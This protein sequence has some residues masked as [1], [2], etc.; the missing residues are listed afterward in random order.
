MTMKKTEHI[1]IDNEHAATTLKMEDEFG[2][3]S[4]VHLTYEEPPAKEST[5]STNGIV[6]AAANNDITSTNEKNA[7]TNEIIASTNE[8]IASAN[9]ITTL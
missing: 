9:Q 1:V 8:I 6:T 7:S 2:D 3:V 5:S 4:S